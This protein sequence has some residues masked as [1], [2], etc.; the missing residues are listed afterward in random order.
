MINAALLFLGL[1]LPAKLSAQTYP[2]TNTLP[3]PVDVTVEFY[4]PNLQNPGC[5]PCG[6]APMVTI[7]PMATVP[8]P[9]PPPPCGISICD[10]KV[11]V[12]A[13][14]GTTIP[15]VAD[16][17]SSPG[18]TSGPGDGACTPTVSIDVLSSGATIAP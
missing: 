7:P 16:T 2:V 15:A 5:V 12:S 8:V 18:P 4:N 11:I 13:I 10:I 1:A 3:C 9:V 6:M 14:A 17:Q